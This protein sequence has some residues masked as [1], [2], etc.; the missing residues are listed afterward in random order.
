MWRLM[1]SLALLRRTPGQPT[2]SFVIYT[3]AVDITSPISTWYLCRCYKAYH[4]SVLSRKTSHR[5]PYTSLLRH[6]IVCV[7]A[8]RPQ[9]CHVLFDNATRAWLLKIVL[10]GIGSPIITIRQSSLQKFMLR[11]ADHLMDPYPHIFIHCLLLW[12]QECA[13]HC[14]VFMMTSLNGNI[15]RVTGHLC[16]EF[17]CHRWWIPL[18][19]ASNAELWCFLWSVPKCTVDWIIMRL[20]IWD[21]IAPIMTSL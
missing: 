11:P 3:F 17:T 13:D 15:F 16:G 18:T 21:A 2:Q 5:H 8:V 12:G 7:A 6:E 10:P 19:K 9:E 1:I 4:I 20:V 14:G